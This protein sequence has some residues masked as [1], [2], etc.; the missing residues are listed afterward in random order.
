MS[1]SKI[2][3]Q[4][5]NEIIELFHSLKNNSGQIIANITNV[6]H[7]TVARVMND[8]FNSK[9]QYSKTFYIFESKINM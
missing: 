6:S 2:P 9:Q 1:N 7:A 3:K 4:K 5:E 8:F